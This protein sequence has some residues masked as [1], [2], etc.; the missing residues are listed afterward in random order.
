MT[1]TSLLKLRQWQGLVQIPNTCLREAALR[2]TTLGDAL[3][4]DCPQYKRLSTKGSVQVPHTQRP[5]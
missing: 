5:K 1:N 3:A 2:H 4:F